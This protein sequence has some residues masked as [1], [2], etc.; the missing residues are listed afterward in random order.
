V[1]YGVLNERA[2]CMDE[3]VQKTVFDFQSTNIFDDSFYNRV[4]SLETLVTRPV[5][6]PKPVSWL[7]I[8]QLVGLL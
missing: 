3:N 4:I 6:I 2:C 5:D 7:S 1:R 8:S